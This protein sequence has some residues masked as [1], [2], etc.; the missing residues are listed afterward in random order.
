MKG[1]KTT[2]LKSN[3]QEV[4]EVENV[5]HKKKLKRKISTESS[6]NPKPKKK[7]LQVVENETEV[8][9]EPIPNKKKKVVKIEETEIEKQAPKMKKKK[10]Q[11]QI[12][13]NEKTEVNEEPAPIKKKIQTDQI[14]FINETEPKMKKK[15]IQQGATQEFKLIRCGNLKKE[16]SDGEKKKLNDFVSKERSKSIQRAKQLIGSSLE[17]TKKEEKLKY[18]EMLV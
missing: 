2:L 4:A 13:E 17:H 14:V 11:T 7:K 16:M 5:I 3:D 8:N 10:L 18:D 12:V 15:K 1:K 9:E 6:E